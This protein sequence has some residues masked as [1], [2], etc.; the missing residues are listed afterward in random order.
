M[1]TRGPLPEGFIDLGMRISLSR[2]ANFLLGPMGW[3]LARLSPTSGPTFYQPSPSCQIAE[4]AMLYQIFLGERSD[5]FFVEIGAYDGISYS[6]TS[7]LAE[8]G[9]HGLLVEPIPQFAEACRS[10]YRANDRIEVVESAVGDK[11]DEIEITVAGSLT[12]TNGALLAAYRDIE[13]SKQS[14]ENTS[15]IRVQQTTLD[16]LLERRA[17][18]RSIDVL[19]IDVEGAEAAVL[20]G[21]SLARWKPRM[22]IIEL[23]HT[24]PDLHSVS[25]GDAELQR[26]IEQGGYSV[27]YKDAINTVLVADEVVF[28]PS[29]PGPRS[30]RG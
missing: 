27:V 21:F 12:T 18:A 22:I 25:A 6:N 15:T 30:L 11:E 29:V 19:V 1:P 4:L 24:H 17:D 20:R 5:G 26:R 2:V 10:R 23:V 9:W 28:S 13:W 7:C 3:S 14:V 16:A 8:R